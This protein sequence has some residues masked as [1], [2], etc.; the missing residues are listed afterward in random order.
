MQRQWQL[1]DRE[2]ERAY[3]RR[4][5]D[6]SRAYSRLAVSQL[7]E[8]AEK[9]GFNP[10]TLLRNGGASSYNAGAGYAPLSATPITRQAP[11]RRAVGGSPVGDAI[12][13]AGDAFLQ[14]FDP[15]AD[16]KREQEYRLIESQIRSLNAA[17]LS[18]VPV[19]SAGYASNDVERR[20]SGKSA[21]LGSPTKPEAGEVEVTN[22]W[23]TWHVDPDV[24]DAAAYEQRYGEFL[25]SAFGGYVYARDNL[26]EISRRVGRYAKAAANS[27]YD[28]ARYVGTGVPVRSP[29]LAP[30]PIIYGN[31][32]SGGGGW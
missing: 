20:P 4:E 28:Y 19:G 17:T 10:L 14:N 23:Q 25:G 9:A 8:D 13:A 22:P 31:D 12:E 2:E 7:V 26:Y 21:A 30:K 18:G 32:K 11:V 3:N 24:R 15:F 5:L 6:E 1:E 29:A 16:Q 27:I